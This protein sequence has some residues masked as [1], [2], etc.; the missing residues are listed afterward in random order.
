MRHRGVHL[1]KANFVV[2]FL[3]A[4]G[5]PRVLDIMTSVGSS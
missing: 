1:H 3:A 5:K 2:C 4:Q